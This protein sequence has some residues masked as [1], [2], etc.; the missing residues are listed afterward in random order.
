MNRRSILW[1]LSLALACKA[2]LKTA[3]GFGPAVMAML[4]GNQQV[5]EVGTALATAPAVL[6]TN[7]SGAPAEGAVVTFTIVAGGGSA[8][9]TSVTTGPDGVAAIGS[10]TLG[11]VS[12]NNRLTATSPGLSGSPVT[13]DATA[14][15]GAPVKAQLVTPPP[16]AVQNGSLFTPQP[17][18]Q[19]Q[20]SFGN[21]GELAGTP[22]TVSL[23]P[24][25]GATLLGTTAATTDATGTARFSDLR[26]EG[27]AG[28]YTLTFSAPPVPAV[29]AATHLGPGAAATLA[30]QA[31]DNQTAAPGAAV[32]VNPTVLV[33]DVGG[34][35]LSG[36]SVTFSIAS[37]GGT[38]AGGSATSN[39][40]GL[41]TSGTW[42]LG[43]SVGTNTLT[44]V[45]A[46]IAP[47]TFTATATLT[48]PGPPASLIK[49][50]GDGQT[51]V[52]GTA[53]AE[54]LV[55]SVRD[56]NGL[57]VPGVSVSWT[58]LSGGGSAGPSPGVTDGSGL[59]RARWTVGTVA[60]PKSARASAAGFNTTFTGTG[61]AGPAA[62]LAK[63]A[64]DNQTATV[65]TAVPVN[66]AVRVTDAFG[67]P[68]AGVTVTFG[69]ASGGGSV[70]SS[71]A[72]TTGLGIA[73]SGTWTLGPAAGANTLTA[74]VAG[75]TGSPATFSAMGTTA[76]P[77]S[78][79]AI[80][81]VSGNG[82]TGIAGDV[83]A[84]SLVVQVQDAGGIGV[85]GVSVTWTILSGGGTVAVTPGTTNAAGLAA[86]SWTLGTLAG[87]NSVRAGAATFTTVF[88]ATGVAGP[89]ATLNRN[90]GNNQS[91]P[92]GTAV[93]VNP[94]V[95]VRDGNG[96]PVAG[97]SVAFAISAGGGTIQS[98]TDLTSALGIAGGG[99]WT[100]GPLAGSN[101]LTASA[102]GLAGSPAVFSATGTPT[103]GPPASLTKIS[104]DNQSAPAGSVLAESLVV[105]VADAGGTGVPGISVSWSV[106]SG[107]GTVSSS[108]VTTDLAGLAAV[109]LTLGTTAGGN[110]VDATAAGFKR[111]FSA[112]GLAGPATS[113]VVVTQPG[114][115][116]SGLV[117]SQ[118]PLIQLVDANGNPATQSG[119][120]VAAAIASGGG[121]L[122]GTV[123]VS[124]DAG[125][126]AVFPNLMVT[127]LVGSRTLSF[128]ATGL[129]G[130]TSAS[131]AITAGP[132]VVMAKQAG[133]N[134]SALAG[135]P[136][137]VNPRVVVTD[138]SG[139]PVSGVTVNFSVTS[140]GGSIGSGSSVTNGL[141]RASG[142]TW[143][144]GPVA[145]PNTLSAVSPGLSGSPAVFSATG[146]SSTG[147]P[148][149]IAKI[150]G[151]NQ[152]GV[153]GNVAAE[154]LVVQVL[155]PNNT[156]VPGVT[157]AWT[158][159]SGGGSVSSASTTTGPTG[160]AAVSWTLG[161]IAGSNSARASAAG[162]TATFTA[163][164]VAGPAVALSKQAG[165]NQSATVGTAV[166]VDPA[167]LVVDS[168]SNPVPGVTVNFTV[169]G[170]NGMIASPV[171]LTDA[172]GI[173]TGGDW[174]LGPV[175]GAN[176]LRVSSSG[177]AGSPTVFNATGTVASNTRIP[178]IDMGAG[179]YLGFPGGLYPT[180]NT[181]P[182]A[183]ATA[184]AAR[185]RNVRP[186][187]F[188][189]NLSLNGKFVLLSIG[190]S[191]TSMEWCTGILTQPCNS[192]SF[193]GQAAGDGSVNHQTMVIANGARPGQ[194]ASTWESPT[195]INYDLVRD[196][197]LTPQGL[198]EKQVEIVWLKVVNGG[199]TT[200]LPSNQSDA[201]RLI[202]Q[203]GN[204][205]R[206]LKVRYPNLEMVFFSS[207][208]YAGYAIVTLNPEPYAYETGFAV[209]W[210]IQA[211]IDQMAN[212]G[213]I[214]DPRAGNLNRTTVAPWIGWGPYL[215]A[216]GLNPRSDGLTWAIADFEP[217]DLT[218]PARP[219]QTKV[220]GMLLNFFKTDP[221]ASCW[222]LAGQVCP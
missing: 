183:H 78:P 127:G 18:V 151:D 170:G 29:S 39:G 131:F 167:V 13:F 48:P 30:K 118:Q 162:F 197:V 121:T 219:G 53:F 198:S 175:A 14:Q 46:G 206:A 82:Q 135:T 95:L 79:V 98:S 143:T 158:V 142:G 10:W 103:T 44:A 214:V 202:T 188:N 220:A 185:A 25:T 156:G 110:S 140:G 32:P 199:P 74:A 73:S 182:S 4:R 155:D 70:A 218:H 196:D 191:N 15:P 173:A 133:D 99:T 125:G 178:L 164:G 130:V 81:I 201:V 111:T 144:L 194:E 117:L 7:E 93:P 92:T 154:S 89:P 31:G 2:D 40:Q 26:L 57:G 148:A 163:T 49:I 94:T 69:V 215:W 100:M 33:R 90:S 36:V 128:A 122:G 192:W 200:S 213:T 161:V 19:L 88:S 66:P 34:N 23:S 190:L 12:G 150:N 138:A 16:A 174:T 3:P 97:V 102:P 43:G 114:N 63:Q 193:M 146:T 132:A 9:G 52:A 209:K 116:Q 104:G 152:T 179:T 210:V 145:G 28:D 22:V 108:T 205:V 147:A 41:A 129:A 91:A 50:A 72:V 45:A 106:L 187:S 157:V 59:A 77:G 222:F 165:D 113:L 84:E 139:N 119:I 38:I 51:A 105:R 85:P 180:G 20:D 86:V 8:T 101:Q 217:I 112:T 149:S 75:L 87:G 195:D 124:T 109:E 11:T 21:P 216:D 203:Y 47:V 120:S 1:G 42:T 176:A 177:L 17:A 211:Q 37:G 168:H 35:P 212:G 123:T 136:V 186:R 172:Q 107:G 24:R 83:V 96:N 60:G 189:G 153:A 62:T 221:R 171:S 54:S 56:A 134:Q 160:L 137:A 141:G 64:G 208:I 115:G 126:L 58:V 67:N 76:S 169:I 207:R 159:L 68:V 71:Q 181:M 6:V 65:S 55:V 204:I 61:I 184:G 5:G 80:V 27:T 166:A